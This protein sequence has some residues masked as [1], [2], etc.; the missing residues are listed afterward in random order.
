[1]PTINSILATAASGL[2][3]QQA[4]LSVTSNNIANASTPGYSRQRAVMAANTA[5]VTP[6]GVFGAGVNVVDVTQVHDALLDANYRDESAAASENQARS[7]A[8]GQ[9]ETILG[10]PSDNGLSS[11]MDQFFSAWSDLASNPTTASDRTVVRERGTEL[12]DQLHQMAGNL[13]Q[14]RQT[15]EARLSD[16]V[17]QVNQLTQQV[18]DLNKQIVSVEAD[19]STASDLRD[20]RNQALDK[21]A[22]LVP[23][24]VNLRENGSVGVSTS[25]VSIVDG[26]VATSLEAVSTAGTWSLRV[27]GGST[28]LAD[29]G[30]SIGGQMQVL[31]HDLPTAN[32]SLDDLA[33]ALVHDVNDAHETGTGPSGKNPVDFFDPAGTSAWT[34]KLSDDVASDPNN[35]A[36]GTPAADGSYR[37]GANDVANK[38]AGLKDTN[39]TGLGKTPDE[40]FQGLVSDVGLSVRSSTDAAT[41]HQTLSDQA[42]S[43]RMSLSGVAVDE[44][45][46]SMIQYQT[47]YQASAHVVNAANEMLQSLLAI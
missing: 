38:I 42:D 29:V 40:Q 14:V 21:L 25:G 12:V 22:T 31:N 43:R 11:V 47:A 17:Q 7:D 5:L 16:G 45:L 27:K 35:I 44:E 39:L 2:K 15:T 9:V 32:K 19:G 34:I 28:T 46:V 13:D 23:I 30:G 10:E 20:S 41:V 6:Q 1:M 26:P 8:L 18:A 37:S 36:A 24:T 3:T 33:G 4:A